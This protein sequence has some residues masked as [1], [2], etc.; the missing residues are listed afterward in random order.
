[1]RSAYQHIVE[2]RPLH[3]SFL[4]WCGQTLS[5]NSCRTLD[6]PDDGAPVCGT[7]EGRA[8]GHNPQRPELL[9]TP[10]TLATPRFC[11]NRTLFAD[12]GS[13]VGRCLACGELAPVKVYGWNGRPKLQVHVPLDLVE[14]C[15]FHAWRYLVEAGDSA[16][17][18]CR[19]RSGGA[20]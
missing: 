10:S 14:G 17:C 6:V 20:A 15:S 9:F 18:R 3:T 13:N 16:V 1:V 5:S 7:C 4:A 11:P 12:A 19:S 8:E 2:G